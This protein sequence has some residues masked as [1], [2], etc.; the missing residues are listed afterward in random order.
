VKRASIGIG[1]AAAL[2]LA[3]GAAAAVQGMLHEEKSLYRNLFVDQ[4]GDERCLL[5]RARRNLGRESCMYLSN[6]DK[7]VFPYARMMLASLYLQPQPK[8]LL[9]IGEG[10]GT[11]PSALQ[12]LLPNT[13]IDL[14]ELD[15]AVDRVARQYFSYQ[16]NANTKVTIQDGRVFVKRAKNAEPY[17]LIMLD[18][19]ADDYIPE[20]MLTKEFLQEVNAIL[21]PGGVLAANTWS[22][23]EL[24][25]HESTTY[26]SVFGP[27]LNLKGD[28]RIILIK[29]GGLPSQAEIAAVAP[30]WEQAF[31]KHGASQAELL[32]LMSRRV[33]WDP[34]S[35]VLTDQ[36]SPSNVLNAQGR[37]AR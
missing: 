22:S 32:P 21:A 16:P 10:G 12:K 5:F 11:L 8:R 3:S 1:V 35:R 31:A 2:V 7:F 19:F 6:P 9:I 23:S 4:S 18:A 37:R 28:N 15:G 36:Y 25:A 14:V 26:T 13:R 34:G 33:D 29:K 27:F 17:D 24:Y 30:R 20:H